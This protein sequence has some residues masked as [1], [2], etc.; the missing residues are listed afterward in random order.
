MIR[1]VFPL[2]LRIEGLGVNCS[3]RHYLY[4]SRIGELQERVIPTAFPAEPCTDNPVTLGAAIR[5]VRT[6]ADLR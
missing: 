2:L 6:Q 3:L 4:I 1:Q 5:A